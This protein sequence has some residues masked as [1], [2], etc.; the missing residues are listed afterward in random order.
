MISD[1]VGQPLLHVLRAVPRGLSRIEVHRAQSRRRHRRRA[2]GAVAGRRSRRLALAGRRRARAARSRQP[3]VRRRAEALELAAVRAEPD[4]RARQGTTQARDLLL[5]QA[6][7]YL[8]SLAT[9]AADDALLQS[10]LASGYEKIGDLQGNPS[11]PNLIALDEAIASYVKAR[12]I[13][14]RLLDATPGDGAQRAALAQ[15]FRVLGNIHGQTNDFEA[16]SK[17]LAVALQSYEAL[18]A[19][20]ARFRSASPGGGADPPRR[21]TEPLG[22]PAVRRLVSVL[23]KGDWLERGAEPNGQDRPRCL[24]TRR[25]LARAAGTGPVVGGRAEGR[26]SRD[27]DGRRDLRTAAGAAPERCQRAQRPV[28]HLLADQQ[29][30]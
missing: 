6:V 9:E 13:R 8:D 30:L 18:L 14:Q 5:Q 27:G 10:E 12:R 17:D 20:P 7:E 19:R 11:N 22:Q 28:V 15:N 26:R 1:H 16:A 4:D 24:P 25:R 3:A 21:R 29:R 23:S 2:G